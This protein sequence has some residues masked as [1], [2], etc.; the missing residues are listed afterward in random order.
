MTLTPNTKA[1]IALLAALLCV[2]GAV[3]W[4]FRREW[5]PEAPQPR[6][7][8][9][10]DLLT[11]FVPA[12]TGRLE[13]R[14]IETAKNLSDAQKTQETLR[15]LVRQGVLADKTALL[16]LIAGADGTV[17]V[18]LSREILERTVPPMEEAAMVYA[19]VNSLLSNLR[20]ARRIH[21]LIDGK[22]V[23]TLHGTVY[24][25]DA[26]EFNKDLLEE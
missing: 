15:E 5:F 20:D 1:R 21:L 13:K 25:Y 9:Q 19:I 3:L 10:K 4:L 14:A 7:E 16:D 22:A 2:L 18:S 23:Y 11:V 26:L 8:I 24:T 6:Q 12:P 17:Y